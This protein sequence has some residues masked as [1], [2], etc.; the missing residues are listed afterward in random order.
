MSR[1]CRKAVILGIFLWAHI[2]YFK[3][4]ATEYKV[5][6]PVPLG[7]SQMAK[8]VCQVLLAKFGNDPVHRE[9]KM[10]PQVFLLEEKLRKEKNS[11]DF[12]KKVD[13]VLISYAAELNRARAMNKQRVEQIDPQEKFVPATYQNT[14]GFEFGVRT[15]TREYRVLLLPRSISGGLTETSAGV[16]VDSPSSNTWAWMIGDDF[17]LNTAIS[18]ITDKTPKLFLLD[19]PKHMKMALSKTVIDRLLSYDFQ[20]EIL[21]LPHD[22][23]GDRLDA[24]FRMRQD[25][26]MAFAPT[27]FYILHGSE[28]GEIKG[29]LAVQEMTLSSE[30]EDTGGLYRGHFA[31]GSVFVNEIQRN[32]YRY[33]AHFDAEGHR[34]EDWKSE[35][36]NPP[37]GVRGKT[38]SNKT[39]FEIQEGAPAETGST[40]ES[41]PASAPK[42]GPDH[43]R[44]FETID[45][46]TKSSPLGSDWE[47]KK[48]VA[49]PLISLPE[50]WRTWDIRQDHIIDE[51]EEDFHSDLELVLSPNGKY[52]FAAPKSQA[53]LLDL[54]TG[55]RAAEYGLNEE[56]TAAAF[57]EN[58]ELFLGQPKNWIRIID[59]KTGDKTG[60]YQVDARKSMAKK[61]AVKIIPFPKSS[62]FVV[63]MHGTSSEDPASF[64][65]SRPSGKVIQL[66]KENVTFRGENQNLLYSF[67]YGRGLSIVP[68]SPKKGAIE[69]ETVSGGTTD[70]SKYFENYKQ[71][72]PYT[73]LK[74]YRLLSPSGDHFIAYDNDS[75][76]HGLYR[77]EKRGL[78]K[79]LDI[80]E[81][82]LKRMWFATDASKNSSSYVATLNRLGNLTLRTVI[83]PSRIANIKGDTNEEKNVFSTSSPV[84]IE[85]KKATTFAF[86]KSGNL[87]ALAHEGS[88]SIWQNGKPRQLVAV[89]IRTREKIRHLQFST[90]EHAIVYIDTQGNLG[91]VYVP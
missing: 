14:A 22:I 72:V 73:K 29:F 53:L 34:V 39:D 7:S 70:G 82:D 26:N 37:L 10:N 64:S 54:T 74:N 3:V 43:P 35:Q 44:I 57:A 45:L 87:F 24:D 75:S 79:L 6:L 61:T 16:F 59:S 80:S 8:T 86:S 90:D 23:D 32:S 21:A 38:T 66:G 51:D 9:L 69:F 56:I 68:F 83:E 2:A 78:E 52:L 28:R 18:K 13:P 17:D 77:Y 46:R 50:G 85:T 89:G 76:S 55:K 40:E 84:D 48:P 30:I 36:I 81:S 49:G 20:K 62:A 65:V 27:Q 1:S 41:L 15:K 33:F 58:G 19:G 91:S 5:H 88:I 4:F 47:T 11:W 31:S 71:N 60:L 67:H 12:L 63:S 42:M 25:L